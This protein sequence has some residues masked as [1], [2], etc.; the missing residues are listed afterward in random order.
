MSA[1]LKAETLHKSFGPIAAVRGISLEVGRGEILGFL[2]PNGAGKTTTMKMLTGFLPPDRGR[3]EICGIDVEKAPL[4]ARGK[5]GYLPEG[6]PLFSDMTAAS[7]LRFVAAARGLTG[8]SRGKAIDASIEAFHLKG[9]LR[10]RIDTLSKGFRRRLALAQALIHDPDVLILDEPTDG[11]DPNQKRETRSLLAA[12]ADNTAIVVSTH[13]LE[14]IETLCTRCVV[15]HRGRTVADEAPEIMKR[16][17]R[18]FGAAVLRVPNAIAT[19]VARA[20]KEVSSVAGVETRVEKS[21]TVITAFAVKG[22]EPGAGIAGL[23]RAKGWAI[24]GPYTDPGRLD[25]VF[26]GLTRDSGAEEA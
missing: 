1:F 24:E 19:E 8:K 6:G 15:I 11:L 26:E 25:D 10:Q 21:V 22:R 23:A 18:Y 12:R 5:F 9:V 17:S 20:V 7:F 3:V 2:G 4:A 16:R 13:I 14:E